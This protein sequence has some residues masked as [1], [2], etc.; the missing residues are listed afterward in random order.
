MI[1][2]GGFHAGLKYCEEVG[3]LCSWF[4]RIPGKS[5]CGLIQL[6]FFLWLTSYSRSWCDPRLPYS[7]ILGVPLQ[8]YF[9]LEIYV[10]NRRVYCTKIEGHM[11]SYPHDFCFLSKGLGYF[12]SSHSAIWS[13]HYKPISGLWTVRPC[14]R[15]D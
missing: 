4:L 14:L 15:I 5:L 8:D 7:W 6:W 2:G 10:R 12:V 9:F 13:K 1:W 11:S 3:H